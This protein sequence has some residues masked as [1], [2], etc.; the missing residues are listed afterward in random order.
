VHDEP[1]SPRTD[2]P[3]ARVEALERRVD[4]LERKAERAGRAASRTRLFLL[5]GAALY[6]LFLYWELTEIV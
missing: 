5:A 3:L 4:E 1:S 6:V 2:G